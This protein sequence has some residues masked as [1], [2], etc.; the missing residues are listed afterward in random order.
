M[1]LKKWCVFILGWM[2]LL[3]FQVLAE[4]TS[5]K[6][7]MVVSSYGLEQGEKQPGYEFDEFAKA[8]LVFKANGLKVDIASPS[9]GEVEADKYNPDKP[10][11]QEVLADKA[12]MAKLKQT[13]KTSVVDPSDYAGVFVIG[14]K[15]AMFDLPKDK[16]LQRLIAS[17]YQGKGAVGAVCHGPAALVNV[18]LSDGSYLVADKAV[19]AFTNEE[20]KLFG[21]K[22]APQFD[23]MLEDKLAERGAK[24]EKSDIMLSHVAVDERLVTGQNPSSSSETAIAFVRQLGI[25]PAP[26][27]AD[28]EEA[29]MALIAG[30]L[31]DDTWAEQELE[32]NSAQYQLPLVG[33]Y[34]Y[35]YIKQ[36]ES[37]AELTHAVTLMKA[38]QAAI[39]NPQLDMQIAKGYQKLGK[40][41]Q[42][43]KVLETLL[44]KHPELETAKE[45]LASL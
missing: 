37:K 6:V 5:N 2:S 25:T 26:Y 29:T 31:A 44:D 19:N 3:S 38:A 12:I 35:Y 20:E 15:G 8:Y 36:A 32:K 30:V 27:Q 17:V 10:Y 34:G 4:Q 40:K 45:M 18:K 11:N 33:M 21:K 1:K 43:R 41:L 7:L 14:G 16:S 39:N 22:W 9:G 28:Q 23:F 24:F 13:L 42:A